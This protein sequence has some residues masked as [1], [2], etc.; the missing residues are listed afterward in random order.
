MATT[1]IRTG[2]TTELA[3]FL[4]QTVCDDD[5][6]RLP[7]P[8][9]INE[10]L[11]FTNGWLVVSLECPEPPPEDFE[12]RRF[13][14]GKWDKSEQRSP[15]SLQPIYTSNSHGTIEVPDVK[16]PDDGWSPKWTV[17]SECAQCDGR[18]YETCDLDHDHECESCGEEGEFEQT[19]DEAIE[20]IAIEQF[21]Y[22]RFLVWVVSKLPDARFC[23]PDE[24]GKI[25]FTFR[26]GRGAMMPI[27]D[28]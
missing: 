4:R 23:E 3:E 24:S 2:T 12:C 10:E 25:E 18:G 27:K 26:F 11:S 6:Y 15:P 22:K 19:V 16:G 28:Q 20:P 9:W 1:E 5:W 14:D 13:V 17:K 21:N 7:I 8:F